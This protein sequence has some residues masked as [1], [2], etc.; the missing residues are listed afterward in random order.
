MIVQEFGE[1]IDILDNRISENYETL[2]KKADK[3]EIGLLTTDKVTKEELPSML[4]DMEMFEERMKNF[5]LEQ[6]S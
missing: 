3:T 4:P 2:M 6:I 1:K 5:T